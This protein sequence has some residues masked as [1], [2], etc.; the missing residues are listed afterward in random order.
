M[1]PSVATS[2]PAPSLPPALVSRIETAL[3]AL[4]PDA[5]RV[6]VRVD[7]TTGQGSKRHPLEVIIRVDFPAPDAWSRGSTIQVTGS[8]INTWAYASLD[9]ATACVPE[10]FERWL[11]ERAQESV[12][13]AERLRAEAQEA[14]RAAEREDIRARDVREALMVFVAG[15]QSE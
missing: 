7:K 6:V 14:L 5:L 9:E 13:S 4:Y 15:G 10:R 11:S 2:K 3:K 12:K 8:F 1:K